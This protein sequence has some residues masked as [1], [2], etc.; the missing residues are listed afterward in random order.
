MPSFSKLQRNISYKNYLIDIIIPFII[1]LFSSSFV[2]FPL[3][4][5]I[6][7]T[8]KFRILFL[9]TF[10]VFT[11]ASHNYPMFILILFAL[12]YK[13]YIYTF[14]QLKIDKQ[15]ID[16]ISIII[17]YALFFSFLYSFLMISSVAFV[18]NINYLFYYIL[19][20]IL[21]LKVLK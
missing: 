1:V 10:L 9:A 6:I 7:I 14:L 16:Y 21:I 15:Y 11:E 20:E 4:I 8:L 19:I 17:V 13:K 18:F 5:G 2:L 12:I 3:F